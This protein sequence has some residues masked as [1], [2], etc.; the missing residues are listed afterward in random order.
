MTLQLLE[1]SCNTLKCEQW[2]HSKE[3]FK[4]D[5]G[6]MKKEKPGKKGRSGE[7]GKRGT[8]ILFPTFKTHCFNFIFQHGC[9]LL[10]TEVEIAQKEL[11]NKKKIIT[12]PT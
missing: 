12:K 4:L 3:A 2:P 6:T 7:Q 8:W 1:A 9:H 11:S 10:Q 5:K